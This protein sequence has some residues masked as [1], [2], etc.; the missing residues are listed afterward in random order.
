MAIF[1]GPAR[2]PPA[3]VQAAGANTRVFIRPL[4]IVCRLGLEEP[5]ALSPAFMPA[6]VSVGFIKK[7]IKL[8]D[9][10]PFITPQA[11]WFL[12]TGSKRGAEA[13]HLLWFLILRPTYGSA[14]GEG[15]NP[16][17]FHF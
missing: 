7:N 5:R 13:D 2:W 1:P 12:H 16:F 6:E 17:F 8:L 15:L 3:H 10:E 14:M 11:C 4:L 9:H